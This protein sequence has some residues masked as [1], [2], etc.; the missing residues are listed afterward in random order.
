M[1]GRLFGERAGAGRA[2]WPER[3]AFPVNVRNTVLNTLIRGE[4]SGNM[5]SIAIAWTLNQIL[6][7][8][9]VTEKPVANEK[10][11]YTHTPYCN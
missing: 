8:I 3:L 2:G 4:V 10:C 5:I 7:I 11:E 9:S 6:S 1:P